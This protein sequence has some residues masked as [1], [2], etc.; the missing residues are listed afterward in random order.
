M[1][2]AWLS[3]A[4][5]THTGY[6][7][8]T[9]EFVLKIR[10]LGHEVAVIA[11]YG[12]QGGVLD[13]NGI[14]VYPQGLAP[15]GN[16]VMAAHSLHFQADITI[17]LMDVWVLDPRI[18]TNVRWVPWFPVDHEPMPPAVKERLPHAFRPIVYSQF[19]SRMCERDGIEADYVPHG[20][21]LN[22]F[23]VKDRLKSRQEIGLPTDRFIVG[24]VA[25]NKGQ[26]ARKAF[27][28]H[29]SAFA[30]FQKTHPDALLYLHTN[31][32]GAGEYGGVDLVAFT[33]NLGLEPGKDILF[34]E[35]YLQL[36]GVP[37][38]TMCLLYNSMDV[39]MSVSTGEGFGLP[40]LEAQACGTP[41]IV[42]D[43]SSMPELCFGG[44]LVE[45]Q[46]SFLFWSAQN[47]WVRVPRVEAIQERLED[48]YRSSGD[49][50]IRERCWKGAIPY[51]SKIVTRRQWK[52]VLER[53]EERVKLAKKTSETLKA[54]WTARA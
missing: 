47:S 32:G 6:G 16:D 36:M 27:C 45:K 4:P 3:N 34:G 37:N 9:K 54:Q 22:V 44:W 19:G 17:S 42:G 5:W 51:D 2:I 26:P 40:I 49:E 7:I 52:P 48:A 33:R 30:A 39:L 14:R 8:Q 38:E 18:M 50:V 53:I 20:V 29:I 21:D 10:D 1:R 31:H 35:Q 46:D 13:W 43:W 11:F 28:E 25:A 41:V 12:L 23:Q 15:Y 24:M